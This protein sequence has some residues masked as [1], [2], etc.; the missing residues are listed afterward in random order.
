MSTLAAGVDSSLTDCSRTRCDGPP[1]GHVCE[2]KV[3]V[4][5][6]RITI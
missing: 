1:D 5:E 3:A 6:A 4:R 2:Y